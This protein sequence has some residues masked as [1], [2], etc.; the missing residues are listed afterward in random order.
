MSD[1]DAEDESPQQRL[2]RF[3]V[4]W[5]TRIEE[6]AST[7]GLRYFRYRIEDINENLLGSIADQVGATV[8]AEQ[9]T[10]ALSI[11]RNVNHHF[12]KAK[13]IN[14]WAAE[15]VRENKNE[16]TK[17]FLSLSAGYGYDQNSTD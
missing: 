15:Y 4:E 1:W 8:S 10:E 3:W 16:M 17:R 7:L 11:S 9:I 14:P 2:V 13:Q 5:H 6:S 12:G